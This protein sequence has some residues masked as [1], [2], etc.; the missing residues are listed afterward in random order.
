VAWLWILIGVLAV[1]AFLALA[2]WVLAG[3]RPRTPG[4]LA[5]TARES[6]PQPEELPGE[7]ETPPP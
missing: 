7:R 3:G 2:R 4:R 5:P 6:N 1:L